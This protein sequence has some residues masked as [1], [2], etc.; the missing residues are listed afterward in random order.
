MVNMIRDQIRQ[1]GIVPQNVA[2]YI[3]DCD[4]RNSKHGGGRADKGNVIT[5]FIDN[6]LSWDNPWFSALKVV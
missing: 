6:G 5:Q 4:A 1:G 2:D 3:N